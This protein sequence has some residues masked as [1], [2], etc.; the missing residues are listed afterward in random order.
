MLDH[1]ED[2]GRAIRNAYHWVDRSTPIMLIMDNAGG[3]GTREV[4][5][6]YM[7]IL[8]EK[9]NVEVKWQV[10]NSPEL[11]MLDLGAWV[12]IQSNVEYNHTSL[13]R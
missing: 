4:K 8:E 13:F 5:E 3:H 10:P 9:F 6:Q 7:H 1:I 12:A 11:N 2:I